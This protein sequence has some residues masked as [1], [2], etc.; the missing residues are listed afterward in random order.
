MRSPDRRFAHALVD[1]RMMAW[2]LDEAGSYAFEVC[3]PWVLAYGPRVA[4]DD[5]AGMLDRAV[6]FVANIPRM[7]W[8]EHGGSS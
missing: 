3:G 7:A 6:D 8:A 4:P 1:A 2:L 5:V